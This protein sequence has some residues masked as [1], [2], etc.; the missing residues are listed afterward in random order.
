MFKGG[1]AVSRPFSLLRS[2][3]FVAVD[4]AVCFGRVVFRCSRLALFRCCYLAECKRET[5]G[6]EPP[7]CRY[8]KANYINLPRKLH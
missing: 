7:K 6:M 2:V 3:L 4:Y 1:S 8:A 5:A